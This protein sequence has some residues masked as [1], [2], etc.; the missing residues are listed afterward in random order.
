MSHEDQLRTLR[1]QL[2]DA[3]EEIR[4]LKMALA[5][6]PPRRPDREEP[7]LDTCDIPDREDSP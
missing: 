3:R 6:R 2:H 7:T 5:K 4:L 1:S